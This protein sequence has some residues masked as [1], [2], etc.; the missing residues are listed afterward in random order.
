MQ[1]HSWGTPRVLTGNSSGYCF[2][3]ASALC[4]VITAYALAHARAADYVLGT[5]N[6]NACP[7]GAAK[8]TDL[9]T[10]PAA[11]AALGKP[12]G[13]AF[14]QALNPSGCFLDTGNPSKVYLNTNATG[15]ASP[16]ARPLCVFGAPRVCAPLVCC[17]L[18]GIIQA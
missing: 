2:G 11:A 15:A 16:L 1:G 13:G 12:Y 18:T 9:S 3:S 4:V 10:C 5:A 14:S 8:I 17:V 6:T 7:A